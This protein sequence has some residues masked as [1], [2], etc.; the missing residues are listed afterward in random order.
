MDLARLITIV[1]T[2]L[3]LIVGSTVLAIVVAFAVT[4]VL[5]KS[6]TA[7][8]T[9]VVGPGINGGQV[10]D[11]NQLLSSLQLAKTYAL[12]ATTV[13]M[14]TDMIS[15]FNLNETSEEFLKSISVETSR[16]TSSLVI[17]VEAPTPELAADIANAI[18][19]RLV[20]QAGIISGTDEV[21]LQARRAQIDDLTQAIIETR[22][23]VTALQRLIDP[24]PADLTA[25]AAAQGQLVALQGSLADLLSSTTISNAGSVAILDPAV[26]PLEPSSPR[27]LINLLIAAV[28][29]LVMGLLFAVGLSSLDDSLKSSVDTQ[30]VLG[31]PIRGVIGRMR[32]ASLSD[33]RY[34]LAML[35]YPR[36]TVSEA[37]RKVRTSLTFGADDDPITSMVVTSAS[38][39]EGKTTVAANLALAYA[40]NG[41]RTILVDADLR[42]P[43]V[44]ELFSLRNDRGLSTVLRS[45]GPKIEPYLVSTEEPNL[46]ILTAGPVP[47]KP[48]ELLASARMRALIE[49][50]TKSAGMVILDSPPLLA[51][52]DAALLSTSVDGALLVVSA[53]RTKK[54]AART[55]TST[56][57]SVGSRI[58]G[59]VVVSAK[60]NEDSDTYEAY[61]AAENEPEAGSPAVSSAR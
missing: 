10:Q 61:P 8:T 44:H 33:P 9:L 39:A 54:A 1:R 17:S 56:L 32:G 4:S 11:Y 38:R 59:V 14:A 18:A 13:T 47:D 28:V 25:L 3:W 53:K 20:D 27:L 34:R 42:Q 29:G 40:Q 51:V 31:L 57:K 48:A 45:E 41:T 35:L 23:R 30:A 36:S 60:G 49:S 52:T 6:Y 12:A 16:D 21:I 46:R 15:T 22:G 26:A 24:K 7:Q 2:Y 37:F 43:M 55:A 19:A 58:L 5:P 50:L